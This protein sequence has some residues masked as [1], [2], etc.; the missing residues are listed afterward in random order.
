MNFE[1]RVKL[2]LYETIAASAVV[3]TS[4][5]LAEAMRVSQSQVDD[6][7]AELAAKRLLVLEKDDPTR[8][9]MAPPFSGI[10][11]G[12]AVE[13]AG[14]SYDA[15][16]AWDVLGIPAALHRDALIRAVDG[17][18]AEPMTL[19]VK[20]ETVHGEGVAHF[21]VPAAQWWDDIVYT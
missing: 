5:Q 12:F 17:F 11:T 16:C 8:I 4:P 13:S 2:T 19:E 7:F 14:K 18:T 3:P 15:P 20:S 1:T 6:A 10:P 21:A 9:R